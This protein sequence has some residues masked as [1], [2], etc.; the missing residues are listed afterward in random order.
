[1]KRERHSQ[2]CLLICKNILIQINSNT[3]SHHNAHI[4]ACLKTEREPQWRRERECRK[5]RKS[6]LLQQSCQSR[7]TRRKYASRWHPLKNRQATSGIMSGMSLMCE[8]RKERS[9]GIAH[10]YG[11]PSI[12]SSAPLREQMRGNT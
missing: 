12:A 3:K 7:R 6:V 1:M 2:E 8:S 11:L 4:F 5:E 9:D 10:C